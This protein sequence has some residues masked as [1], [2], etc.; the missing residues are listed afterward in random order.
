MS[1]IL[2]KEKHRLKLYGEMLRSD[3]TWKKTKINFK[4]KPYKGGIV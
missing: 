2:D 1:K 3:L 4:N